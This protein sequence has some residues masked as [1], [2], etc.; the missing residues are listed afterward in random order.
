MD[1]VLV[2]EPMQA[3]F[4]RTR[5]S[6]TPGPGRGGRG[7]ALQGPDYAERKHGAPLPTADL[8][9]IH[10]AAP[11]PSAVRLLRALEDPRHLQP[12]LVDGIACRD[13]QSPTVVVSK[14]HVRGADLLLGLGAQYRQIDGAQEL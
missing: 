10:T 2:L 5:S 11:F 12:Y 6:R 9:Q 8:S 14:G 4:Q 3:R 7:R 1:L 13:I